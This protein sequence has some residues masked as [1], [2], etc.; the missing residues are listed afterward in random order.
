MQASGG[1]GIRPTSAWTYQ[2]NFTVELWQNDPSDTGPVGAAAS[3]AH[4]ALG[5][6]PGMRHV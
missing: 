2:S 3:A 5:A 6:V 1:R 4:L